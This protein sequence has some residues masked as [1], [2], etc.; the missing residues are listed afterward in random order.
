MRMSHRRM[1]EAPTCFGSEEVKFVSTLVAVDTGPQPFAL[2]GVPGEPLEAAAGGEAGVSAAALPVLG[3]IRLGGDHRRTGGADRDGRHWRTA[4]SARLLHARGRQRVA[5]D[6]H[7]KLAGQS[8]AVEP[9]EWEALLHGELAVLAVVELPAV[10]VGRLLCPGR[11]ARG[12]PVPERGYFRLSVGQD[13]QLRLGVAVD[14]PRPVATAGGLIEGL[15]RVTRNLG[16]NAL[17]A[18]VEP[19]AIRVR[20][21]VPARR[22]ALRRGTGSVAARRRG[23]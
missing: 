23:G 10:V 20:V 6:L 11:R 21:A 12:W 3:A 9:L 15:Q 22:W 8:L 14:L 1:F 19:P 13:R 18:L 4:S 16:Q 17:E 5:V 2:L 7:G